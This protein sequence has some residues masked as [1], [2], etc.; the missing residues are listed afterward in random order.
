MLSEREKEVVALIA[1]AVPTRDMAKHLGISLFTVKRHIV[2]IYDKLG[3]DSR[4]EI[5]AWAF[6]QERERFE[7]QI[8]ELNAKLT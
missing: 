3:F 8:A 4:L 1:D 5:A 7:A 6:Q 2:N